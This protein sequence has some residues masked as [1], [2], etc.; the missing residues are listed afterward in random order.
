MTLLADLIS[1]F[2]LSLLFSTSII[3]NRSVIHRRIVRKRKFGSTA[4]YYI[5][6]LAIY[7]LDLRVRSPSFKIFIAA[8]KSLS[9]FVP[10]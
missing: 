3:T 2:N 9:C 10:H 8:F 4:T 7:R 6:Y 1:C 5:T